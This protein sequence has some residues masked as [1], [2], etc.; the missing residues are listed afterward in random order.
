MASI[1]LGLAL[2]WS[3]VEAPEAQAGNFELQYVVSPQ[4][5]LQ[6]LRKFAAFNEWLSRTAILE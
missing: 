1:I 2:A 3:N 5:P 4:S 6:E